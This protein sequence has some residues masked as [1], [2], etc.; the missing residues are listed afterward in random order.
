MC[1]LP[2]DRCTQSNREGCVC[3][4]D[5]YRDG[6]EDCVEE[7]ECGCADMVTGA[8]YMVRQYYC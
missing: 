6:A 5:Y 3:Q 2:A 8:Y 4:T 7:P 1:G